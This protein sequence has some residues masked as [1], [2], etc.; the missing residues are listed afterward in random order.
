MQPTIVEKLIP[1]S[2]G[3]W[4]PAR[5]GNAIKY[6]VLHTSDSSV[7]SATETFMS[8]AR[9]ASAHRIVGLDGSITVFVSDG[10]T[11]W[12]ADNW[13][14]NEQS[15]GLE[16]EDNA[17]PNDAARTDA[18]Y[19]ASAWQVASWC[20][21]YGIPCKKVTVD[22]KT[23][24]AP[25]IVLHT[26]VST[27]GTSC[28][29]G[30]DWNRV[31]SQ[32]QALL[33]GEATPTVEVAAVPGVTP[34]SGNIKVT[35]GTLKVHAAL[36]ITSE[37]A[38]N[39]A[40]TPDGVVHSGNV[41]KI[42]GYAYG[43]QVGDSAVWLH[44]EFGK[45]LFADD[46]DFFAAAPNVPKLKAAPA[47]EFVADPCTVTVLPEI[48]A[49]IRST[50]ESAGDNIAKSE[51]KGWSAPSDGF[52]SN[53]GNINGNTKWWR[54]AADEFISDEV[55]SV[56]ALIPAAP[57]PPAPVAP[58]TSTVTPTP[59]ITASTAATGGIAGDILPPVT[60]D[61]EPVAPAQGADPMTVRDYLVSF[62]AWVMS[63]FIKK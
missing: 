26:E 41:V 22:A 8:G 37:D 9:Q 60:P 47:Y 27:G 55:V 16:H 56:E 11:A 2:V 33:G 13:P 20:K 17:Q 39:F 52:I 59:V 44:D 43:M 50:P 19:A 34:W 3:D 62:V 54:L 35:V 48:G 1:Q 51:D 29:D 31:I 30:L 24:T 49:N 4:T 58:V 12:H 21:A 63:P 23:P 45:F 61:P 28:P 53:G 36:P 14:V 32:A 57:T 15:L 38:G 6:I 42:T 10:N 5:G 40:N 7:A 25:G 18:L 46:T